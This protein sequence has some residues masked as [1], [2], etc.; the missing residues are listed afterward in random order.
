MSETEMLLGPIFNLVF[1][2]F[3]YPTYFTEADN[4]SQNF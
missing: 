4:K 3:T 2:I 1:A